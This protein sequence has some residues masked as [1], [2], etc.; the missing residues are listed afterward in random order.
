M[1]MV[2]YG[3]VF[4]VSDEACRNVYSRLYTDYKKQIAWRQLKTLN[5]N[6]LIYKSI[7]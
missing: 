3:S 1:K 2:L 7:I 5:I 6:W 4:K